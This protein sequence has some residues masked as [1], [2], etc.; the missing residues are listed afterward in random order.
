[1]S[2]VV[3]HGKPLVDDPAR[4]GGVA[5]LGMGEEWVLGGVAEPPRRV[6][7][8]GSSTRESRQAPRRG[9]G[10]ARGHGRRR[11]AS[12]PQDWVKTITV[13]A[14]GSRRRFHAVRQANRAIH[15]VRRR[16]QERDPRA[17]RP[18]RRPRLRSLRRLPRRRAA[19][20]GPRLRGHDPSLPPAPR[21]APVAPRL[22]HGWAGPPQPDH[23]TPAG[24]SPR[25]PRP[26]RSNGPAEAVNL[27]IEKIRRIGTDS[28]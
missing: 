26:P 16:A 11:L 13:A 20:R 14:S 27:L 8:R 17:P 15:D 25:L 1:M 22:R 19:P 9:L 18:Q 21:P 24:R 4:S 7:D 10:T 23:L 3:D 28:L 5:A 12:R 6:R 2:A